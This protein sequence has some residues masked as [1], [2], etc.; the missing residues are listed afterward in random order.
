[1]D[2]VL[3]HCN[4]ASPNWHPRYRKAFTAGFNKH[5]LPTAWT[6]ADRVEMAHVDHIHVLFGPNYYPNTF[7]NAERFLCVDRCSIGDIND[8]VTIGWGGWGGAGRYPSEYGERTRQ[9]PR[10]PE[11]AEFRAKGAHTVI[12]GEYPSACDS[13]EDIGRFYHDA[14]RESEANGLKPFFK[15]HPSNKWNPA[16]LEV[17]EGPAVL[18]SAHTIYT[19]K[20]SFG[21]HCRLV[22]LP[23]A[24]TEMSLAGRYEDDWDTWRQWL[25]LTQWH[26]DEI[27]DGTFWEFLKDA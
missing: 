13:K 4:E 6:P 7:S 21:V 12:L 20:T 22:G 1:M 19:Y 9:V 26:I 24:A 18:R 10:F 14:A 15:P 16:K 25:L 23:V 5:L 3:L 27:K 2:S 11:P 17:Q 8:H